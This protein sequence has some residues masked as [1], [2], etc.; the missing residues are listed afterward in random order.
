MIVD[1]GDVRSG[2]LMELSQRMLDGKGM[3]VVWL[4]SSVGPIFNKK[5]TSRSVVHAGA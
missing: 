2:V 3:W 1:R 4:M 5:E